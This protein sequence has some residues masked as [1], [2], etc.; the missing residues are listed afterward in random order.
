MKTILTHQTTTRNGRDI[1]VIDSIVS[2]Y[3]GNQDQE[4]AMQ[5]I[6]NPEKKKNCSLLKFIEPRCSKSLSIK[7]GKNTNSVY[8]SSHFLSK[9]ESGRQIPYRF[10]MEDSKNPTDVRKRLEEYAQLVNME[11][12]PVDAIAIE[13]CIAMYP[14]VKMG[15]IISGIMI[16]VAIAMEMIKT[17]EQ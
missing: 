1:V 6:N 3:I 10:W 15:S 11:I 4:I 9:D 7:I 16:L 2:E 14:K 17:T 13:T 12:N 8:I 5:T